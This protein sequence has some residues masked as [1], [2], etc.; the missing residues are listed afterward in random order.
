M[1]HVVFFARSTTYFVR[2]FLQTDVEMQEQEF[3]EK[4]RQRQE[5]LVL[6][7]FCVFFWNVRGQM[8]RARTAAA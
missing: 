6:L 5:Y 3:Y 4:E 1:I 2:G 8:L 7:N